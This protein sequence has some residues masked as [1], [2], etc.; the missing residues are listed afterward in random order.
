MDN[1][2]DILCEHTRLRLIAAA[3]G[4]QQCMKMD[5]TEVLIPGTDKRFL[6]GGDAYLPK[7][8][9]RA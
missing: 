2:I 5:G 3:I 9:F 6:I 4:H 8:V 1:K 7:V